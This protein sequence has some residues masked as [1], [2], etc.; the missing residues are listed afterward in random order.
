MAE[1]LESLY[2][3]ISKDKIIE[4]FKA[5]SQIEEQN[6]RSEMEAEMVIDYNNEKMTIAQLEIV[7]VEEFLSK[8]KYKINQILE[9]IKIEKNLNHIFINCLDIINGFNVIITAGENTNEILSKLLNI[10]F[11]NNTAK[12]THL[13]QRKELVELL[14]THSEHDNI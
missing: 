13:I 9:T 8:N 14:L 7:N 5:K 11:E 10:T 1:W 4:I 2:D 3:E 6:L 12:T